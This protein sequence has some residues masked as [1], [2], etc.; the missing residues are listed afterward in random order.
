MIPRTVRPVLRCHIE[1]L[2]RSRNYSAVISIH[3]Q[4]FG[5]IKTNYKLREDSTKLALA[6]DACQAS[7]CISDLILIAFDSEQKQR[8]DLVSSTSNTQDQS[9]LLTR[10]RHIGYQQYCTI[11][12]KQKDLPLM[13]EVLA[14][15]DTEGWGQGILKS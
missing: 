14:K 12:K 1:N 5:I 3:F 9:T 8:S 4:L 15:H 13:T 6:I 10:P 2:L 7:I 11:L